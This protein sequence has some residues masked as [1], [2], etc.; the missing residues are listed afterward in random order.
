[1]VGSLAVAACCVVLNMPVAA[2]TPSVLHLRTTP[3]I[4]RHAIQSAPE[5]NE[6]SREAEWKRREI[7]QIKEGRAATGRDSEYDTEMI[8]IPVL[9]LMAVF[10][11]LRLRD[12]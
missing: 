8:V 10:G 11:L 3:V 6:D 2:G 9:V 1:M 7:L 4:T 5:D 12:F